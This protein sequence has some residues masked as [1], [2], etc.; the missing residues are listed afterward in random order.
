MVERIPIPDQKTLNEYASLAHLSAAV[1]RL[2]A[3]AKRLVPRLAGRHV[4]MVNSTARGGG[5]AEMLPTQIALLRE[6]GVDADWLVISTDRQEFFGFT[7]RLHNLIHG[8]GDPEISRSERE[9]YDA[10]SRENADAMRDML[11]PDDI[12]VVHDPQPLGAGAALKEELGVHTVWRCHIGLDEHVPQTIAAWRFMRPFAETYDQAVFSAPEY[13]PGYLAGRV[14]IIH[15]AIDPLSEKNRDLPLHKLVGIIWNAD[16]GVQSGPI[17]TADYDFKAMRLQPDGSFDF[18]TMPEDIGL[19]SRP[20]ITQVSRWDRLK[21]FRPLMQ[22]FRELKLRL[23][24][25]VKDPVHRRRLELVRLVLAGPDPA[26]V[27]DDPEGLQVIEELVEDYVAFEPDIQADIALVSLPMESAHFNALMVNAIQ[28]ASTIVVQNSLREGF[29]LTVTEAMWKQK[30]VLGNSRAVGLRQQIRDR[31]DGCMITDPEDTTEI[32]ATLNEMLADPAGR[33]TWGNA[34]QR[35]VHE[36]FLVLS[37]I[38]H[39][40]HVLAEVVDPSWPRPAR[41]RGSTS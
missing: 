1:S 35:H 4:W 27:Q 22:G 16:L 30:A 34:A 24:N 23:S 13:I 38:S 33:D 14:A 9:L 37:Q 19:L 25:G 17:L 5:V 10:V 32:A 41:S 12:L 29:G 21:G 8:E 6:L 15:P 26:S 18:A 36:E 40:L 2:R 31:I 7:K 28:R 20:I 39:W 3:E 11:S